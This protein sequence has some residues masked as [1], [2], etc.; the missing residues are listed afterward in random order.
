MRMRELALPCAVLARV[1][2]DHE[3]LPRYRDTVSSGRI[4][5]V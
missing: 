3:S 4:L 2:Q 5:D 1:I